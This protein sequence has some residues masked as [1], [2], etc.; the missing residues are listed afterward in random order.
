MRENLREINVGD[1]TGMSVKDT[2]TS[3]NDIF[4]S[5]KDDIECVLQDFADQCRYCSIDR[6]LG[7]L[8]ELGHKLGRSTLHEYLQRMKSTTT[9]LYLESGVTIHVH[10]FG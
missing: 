6:L 1:F 2:Y 5:L 9:K 4:Q 3:N 10:L 8:K 7:H